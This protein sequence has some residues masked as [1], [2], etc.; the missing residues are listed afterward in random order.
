MAELSQ[1]K[2]QMTTFKKNLEEFAQ[3]YKK[4]INKNPEFRKYFVDMCTKIGVD[5]LACR[6]HLGCLFII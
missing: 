5:P 1:A 6:T 2:E 3:K 4:E